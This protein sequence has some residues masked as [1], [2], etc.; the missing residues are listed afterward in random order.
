MNAVRSCGSC[1]L[2]CKL[3][4]ISVFDKP[5]N[6]WCKN[7]TPGKGCNIW[8]DRPKT[9]QDFWCV[10]LVNLS[11]PDEYRPDKIKLYVAATIKEEI[12]QVFV[13]PTYP[14]AWR[15]GKGKEVIDRLSKNGKHVFIVVGP[16]ERHF[17]QGAG[18]PLPQS[19]K[20][21][22]KEYGDRVL[23]NEEL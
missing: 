21:V 6:T 3:P 14:R 11:L 8:P 4:A 10:W 22:I 15:E 13:D 2:C 20:N 17:V 5:M 23:T 12:Y 7:C 16:R 18:Q 1:S 9:C 19:V